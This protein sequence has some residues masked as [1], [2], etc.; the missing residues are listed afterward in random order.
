MQATEPSSALSDP[1]VP[2]PPVPPAVPPGLWRLAARQLWLDFRAGELRLV[3]AAVVLAV[4]ALTAVGFFADRLQ[5]GL[6]RD[7]AQLLGGDLV[8]R[9]DQPLPAELAAQARKAG[10]TVGSN[11]VFPSMARADEA[12]GGATRLVS[13]KAVSANYP[14][15]GRLGVMDGPEAAPHP[16]GAP[17][18]G[19]VWVDA[20][21]TEALGLAVGQDL[22]LGDARFRIAGLIATEPDRG[23]GFQSFAPRVMLR[24]EDLPATGLIQPASRVA[25]RLLVAAEPAQARALARYTQ[26]V[27]GILKA[28]G[29]R[30][31]RLDTLESGRPEMRQTLDRASKFLNLVALLA[32]LL[33]AVA[34]AI[35]ARDFAQ[36]HLDDCAMLRVLGL[37]QRRIAAVYL[38]EFAALGL[39]G[40]LLGV[41][42]GGA[43]H[44]LFVTLLA[45]LIPASLPPPT[46]WP[47][48]LG[49]GVGLTL[50]MG[51]GVPPVLQLAQVPPLRVLRREMGSIRPASAGVLGAAALAFGAL[52]VVVARDLTLG[53]IAV[54]GFAVALAL[55]AGLSWVAVK[56]LGRWVPEAGGPDWLVI[57]TRQVA[58]RPGFTML[59]VSALSVGLMALA[60]LVL[61]R[62]DLINSWRQA[63]PPDA[64][65]R[66]V[67]NIQPDQAADFRAMLDGAGVRGYDWYPMIRGRLLTI[68]GAEVGP[69]YAGNDE[70][71]RLVEREFN[72]SHAAQIPPHNLLAGGRWQ[73]DEKDGLSVEAGLAEKLGLKLGDRLRFDIT[74]QVVEGKVTSLRKVDWGSMRVNFFVMFPQAEMPDL[75]AT[76]IAA[77]KAPGQ[78][79][80]DNALTQRFPNITAIDVTAT[81]AQ[82]QAVIDEV[83][84][85][86]QYLFVFSVAAGLVVL[87]AALGATREA[88]AH[89]YAVM[90]ACGASSRL[91]ARVQRAELLGVGALAGGLATLGAVAVGWALARFVFEFSWTAAPWVP[92]LG[93]VAGAL[94]ALA[95]GWWGLREVL[96]RPVM[97]TLRRA[98]E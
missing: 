38:G 62:T 50:L 39:G 34:V 87:F 1:A 54:G 31:V 40:S 56:L 55:F 23:T 3:L 41:A 93:M 15:R 25:Y 27:R 59:Q 17:A 72:L 20:A 96:R 86:V 79:G 77:F 98:A 24:E 4:A 45:G 78:K 70:A 53:A 92:L 81:L 60:L 2:P 76:Y 82:V 6:Q 49:L 5:G 16:G 13:V 90:R 33:S 28:E 97:E 66:F 18:P 63:T 44:L 26:W 22:L 37:S 48:L 32:A 51:F 68:N 58:A 57:A 52:L 30:G 91:L 74:G 71:R 7:A 61:L 69:R 29:A 43:L 9:G 95:A 35:A 89:E 80:F 88:R 94:L 14:L 73:T 67:I 42:L 75:P 46:V 12:Q 84:R 21:V 11:A 8:V 83:I 64:P 65:N 10:L 47:A 85:A 19:Q 36:R